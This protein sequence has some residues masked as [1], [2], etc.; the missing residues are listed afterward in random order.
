MH[1]AGHFQG[2]VELGTEETLKEVEQ[3]GWAHLQ[4]EP[5]APAVLRRK[6]SLNT[7]EHHGLQL[8]TLGGNGGLGVISKVPISKTGMDR[9]RFDGG[10]YQQCGCEAEGQLV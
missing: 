8:Q 4:L 1:V 7:V 3:R 6:G 2:V 9:N 5:S 10:S